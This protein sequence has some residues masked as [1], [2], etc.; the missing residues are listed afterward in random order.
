MTETVVIVA[1]ISKSGNALARKGDLEGASKP[2]P[3]G[4]S[5]VKVAISRVVQ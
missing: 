1:R 2:V 5:G 3:P 4:A